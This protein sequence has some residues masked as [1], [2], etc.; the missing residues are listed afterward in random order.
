MSDAAQ[1]TRTAVS[2]LRSLL[3]EIYPPNLRDAGLANAL[4][5]LLA[6]PRSRG[7]RADLEVD[8]GIELPV[9][10]EALLFRAAQEGLRNVISHADATEVVVRVAQADRQV[11]L[12]V[13]DNGIGIDSGEQRQSKVGHAGLRLLSDL[14][15]RAGG[16]LTMT[17]ND[18]PGSTLTV[19]LPIGAGR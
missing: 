2:A 1:H 15:G 12:A 9:D 19:T 7:I 18:G 6:S 3:I 5:G 16:N 17:S 4:D 11:T 14:V 8:P 13:R 10:V